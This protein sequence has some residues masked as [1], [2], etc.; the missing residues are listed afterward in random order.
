MDER[1][2]L[3]A[4]N[5]VDGIGSVKLHR[6]IGRFSCAKDVFSASENELRSVEGI[7]PELAAKITSFNESALDAELKDASEKNI[8]IITVLD[9]S[10]PALLRDIYDPPPVLYQYGRPLPENGLKIGIV[11]TRQVTEYGRQVVKKLTAEMASS[12]REISV[13]SG[14]AKG[15]DCIAHNEASRHGIYNAAVLGYG[16]N[17]V[18]PFHAHYTAREIIKNGCLMSEFPLNALGLKQNFPRRNRVISGLSH[19]CVVVEAGV[20]SGALITADAALEQGREV[21]A[22]PGSVFSEKSAGTNSLIRQGAKAVSCLDDILE[23]ISQR[24]ERKKNPQTSGTFLPEGLSEDEKRILAAIGTEKKHIDNIAI[25]SN[26]DTVKLNSVMT[27][28]EMK[29][30][31]RQLAGKNFT[32]S[33]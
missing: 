4:L 20:K 23:E 28:L 31:V 5:M 6:L 25:E 15:V 22:V 9:T 29:G 2:A 26:M 8:S 21:F 10:Y 19:G 1:G 16:L 33:A 14:M 13:I 32:R 7:G 18:Y 24:Y 11:G 30:I 17:L 27:I 3:I 12:G